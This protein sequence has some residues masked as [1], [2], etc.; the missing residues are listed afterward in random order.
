MVMKSSTGSTKIGIGSDRHRFGG[1]R[2]LLLGGVPIPHTRTLA[3][4]SDADVLLHAVIDAILGALGEG[5][6]GEWFP[7][8]AAENEGRDSRSML[9]KVLGADRPTTFRILNLDC[10]VFAQSPKLS[11]YK[12]AIRQSLADLL[13]MDV[14]CV[15]VK[16]KTGERVGAVGREEAIDAH[17]VVLIEV[18]S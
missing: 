12:A 17:A 7:D 5:D 15:N 3:G 4:H 11:Q 10:T 14:A 2:P 18:V 6:I 8:S 9:Q 13:S 16:A 1:N